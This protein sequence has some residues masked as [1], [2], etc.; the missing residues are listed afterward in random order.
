MYVRIVGPMPR[1][2]LKMEKLPD[3]AEGMKRICKAVR[4]R[5]VKRAIIKALSHLAVCQKLLANFE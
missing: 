2:Q 3:T 4:G 5:V 1:Q